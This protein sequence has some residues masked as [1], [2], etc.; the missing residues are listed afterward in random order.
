MLGRT[1]PASA[2]R[3]R[4]RRLGGR[5]R[6]TRPRRAPPGAVGEER[7]GRSRRASPRRLVDRPLGQVGERLRPPRAAGRS[8][9]CPSARA[10]PR[11]R[12]RRL[13]AEPRAPRR[14]PHRLGPLA[15]SR[16]TPP[17]PTRP[18]PSSNC[19]LTIA[20]TRAP[21]ASSGDRREDLGEGDEAD[22]D[23]D[24]PGRERQIGW[25]QLAGVEALDRD[26]RSSLRSHQSSWPR[27][28]SSAITCAAPRCS[29]QSVKPP[30]EAPMSRQRRPSSRSE[31][32]QRRLQLQA[33]ARDVGA[34]L[35][36]MRI[37]SANI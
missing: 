5:A 33:A 13:E 25:G 3:A 19:G 2:Y 6:G 35:D 36:S 32:V 29:R 12:P 22:V 11:R 31:A 27:P 18:R 9:G 16:T 7:D 24:Q 14:P 4:S 23:R 1:P 20:S 26:T 8:R 34:P 15:G 28:T 17:R 37:S 10:C 21:G 30:V